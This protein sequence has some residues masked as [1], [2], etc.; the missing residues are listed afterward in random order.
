MQ[1]TTN[2]H[3]FIWNSNRANNCNTYLITSE[4]MNILID[5]GHAAYFDHVGRS[6]KQ[7][8]LTINDINIIICTHVH[9]DHVE[10]AQLFDKTQALFA[11]HTAEWAL[12]KELMGYPDAFLEEKLAPFTPDFFLEEGELKIGNVALDVFHTPGH[13]PGSVTLFWR[14]ARALFTGDLI[15]YDGIGRTDLPGGDGGRLKDSIRRVSALEAEWV[16]SGHGPVV[17]G[18]AEVKNNFDRVERTWFGYI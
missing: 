2:L 8:G 4:G 15:F 7:I 3:A 1:L 16:L 5:P 12:V 17:S 13:S 14:S 18:A 9:P 10:A 6:L 11:I